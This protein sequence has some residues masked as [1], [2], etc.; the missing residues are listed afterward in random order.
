MA[1]WA[2]RSSLRTM[3][4]PLP[5]SIERATAGLLL[6]I[7]LRR[8][9]ITAPCRLLY[10]WQVR[11]RRRLTIPIITRQRRWRRTIHSTCFEGIWSRNYCWWRNSWRDICKLW[12]PRWEALS[13]VCL[14]FIECCC[15]KSSFLFSSCTFRRFFGLLTPTHYHPC[16]QNIPNTNNQQP[17]SL[18]IHK[19]HKYSNLPGYRHKHARNQRNQKTPQTTSQS[20]GIHLVGSRNDHSRRRKESIQIPTHLRRRNRK[21]TKLRLRFSTKNTK[22]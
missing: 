4:N 12:G 2:Y 10:P 13:I 5:R 20:R 16:K 17:Q 19:I 15:L 18:H 7:C 8:R 21:P 22:N 1:N 9:T 6:P 3:K 11:R 14:G